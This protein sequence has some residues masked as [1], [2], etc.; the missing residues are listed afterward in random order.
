MSDISSPSVIRNIIQHHGL[1]P[2]KRLGQNFLIDRNVLNKIADSCSISPSQYL[3]EIGPGLGTLTQELASRSQG[4]FAI[5]I[6]RRLEPI[7]SALAAEKTNIRILYQDILKIDI[8]EELQKAFDLKTIPP[9][10]ICAN[11]PY[12]ITTPIIFQLLEKCPHM[13]SA[14][15]MMQ[16]EVGTRIMAVPGNKD[17]GRLTLTI[18]YYARVEHIMNV[19]HHCFYPKPEV[20]S[21][22]LKIIP[23]PTKLY[24]KNEAVFKR[25]INEAFQKR[26][27]TILNITTDF[28]GLE[29]EAVARELKALGLNPN[30]RPENLSLEDIAGLLNTFIA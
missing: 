16:K 20:D 3:V 30:L 22:V 4:V 23:R 6:D 26:R 27:K 24:I 11:I 7:L 1:H 9:Y 25:F 19:S 28:F 2:L 29:K 12:N 10:Q 18:A 21:A 14:T 17:Y 5:E 13:Q 8:E 15:L